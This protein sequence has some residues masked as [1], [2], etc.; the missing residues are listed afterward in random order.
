M[1]SFILY[2]L[3][4]RITRSVS[5]CLFFPCVLKKCANHSAIALGDICKPSSSVEILFVY[6]GAEDALRPRYYNQLHHSL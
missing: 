2:D 4:F 3:S 6:V 5:A 1:K